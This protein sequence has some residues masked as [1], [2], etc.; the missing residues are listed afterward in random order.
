MGFSPCGALGEAHEG[1]NSLY[2]VVIVVQEIG[3][4]Q[5]PLT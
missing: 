3:T 5:K 1:S 4:L 2:Y